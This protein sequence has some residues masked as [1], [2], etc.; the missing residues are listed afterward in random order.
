MRRRAALMEVYPD[1]GLAA[2]RRRRDQAREMVA[3]G[4]DPGVRRKAVKDS[5]AAADANT[6]EV[7]A[8]QWFMDK[9]PEWA[10]SNHSRILRRLENNIFPWLGK[11]P[12]TEIT[13]P[14]MLETLKRIADR[15]CLET[16]NKTRQS[17]RQ[18][19]C[20]RHSKRVGFGKPGGCHRRRF[21]FGEKQE[22]CR[23]H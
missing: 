12:I 18:I 9:S 21:I 1:V 22:L 6:F 17:C 5:K 11:K 7:V 8:R 10:K 4:L 20:L 13:T 2:A 3:D 16:A 14:L 23:H 19:F 15:G